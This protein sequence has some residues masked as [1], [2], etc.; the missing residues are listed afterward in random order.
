MITIPNQTNIIPGFNINDF[1]GIIEDCAT[2]ITMTYCWDFDG[3]PPMEAVL[4]LIEEQEQ[5]EEREKLVQLLCTEPQKFILTPL[6]GYH[7][8]IVKHSEYPAAWNGRITPSK[9]KLEKWELN[10][11][12]EF[13][14]IKDVTE[15][16]YR[17]QNDCCGSW[18]RALLV[19]D[20]RFYS[21]D[22]VN[23]LVIVVELGIRR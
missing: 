6:M 22:D 15:G 23:T 9:C 4:D 3:I 12:D 5:R 14:T 8:L 18:G 16:I 19:S 11:G 2:R 7:N 20:I 21:T 13:I 17:M 1:K 10:K